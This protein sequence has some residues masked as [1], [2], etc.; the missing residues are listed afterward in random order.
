MNR[1]DPRQVMSK[2]HKINV[3]LVTIFNPIIKNLQTVIRENVPMLCSGWLAVHPL[4]VFVIKD[5]L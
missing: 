4:Y 5:S 3:N 1:T 2:S